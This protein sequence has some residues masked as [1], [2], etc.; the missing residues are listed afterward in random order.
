MSKESKKAIGP[1]LGG[2]IASLASGLL[3]KKKTRDGETPKGAGI[4]R[5][6]GITAAAASG[7][8]MALSANGVIDCTTYGMQ[9]EICNLAHGIVLI[10]GFVM[11]WIGISKTK[12]NTENDERRNTTGIHS[13]E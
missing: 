8:S 9:P 12:K 13:P 1:L 3:S 4:L 2:I 6:I 11:Y 5:D 10:A 7:G